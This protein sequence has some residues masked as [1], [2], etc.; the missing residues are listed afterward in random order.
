MRKNPV[1]NVPR[2]EP[3][4]E[5]AYIFPTTLPVFARLLR[6]NLTTTGE[7]IPRRQEGMK[8]MIVVTRRIRIIK[9]V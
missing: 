8:K 5:K 2:M 9:L 4:V 6:V 1:A 3:R 7:I